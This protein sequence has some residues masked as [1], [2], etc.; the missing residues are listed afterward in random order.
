M[1]NGNRTW[2]RRKMNCNAFVEG[3]AITQRALELG[4]VFIVVLD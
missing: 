3:S 1:V 4:W 2:L